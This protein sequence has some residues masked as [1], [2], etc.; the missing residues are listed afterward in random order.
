MTDLALKIEE[1]KKEYKEVIKITSDEEVAYLKKPTVAIVEEFKRLK[2][3]D[4]YTAMSYLFKECV[5]EKKEYEDEFILS[6]SKSLLEKIPE[7]TDSTINKEAGLDGMKKSAALVRHFFNV[8]PY[9]LVIDEFYKLV[10]EALWL[11]EYKNKQLEA[12]L[13]EII[14]KTFANNSF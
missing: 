1:W 2:E 7:A 4:V 13:S 9:A 10:A 14:V 11:Q 3:E 12:T 5:L 6:A 8:D